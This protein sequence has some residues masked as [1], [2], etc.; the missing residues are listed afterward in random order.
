MIKQ[1][2]LAQDASGMWYVATS[3][4]LH[5]AWAWNGQTEP[6]KSILEEG[7]RFRQIGHTED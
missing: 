2:W 7:W 6:P 3:V 5:E 4:G 1:A